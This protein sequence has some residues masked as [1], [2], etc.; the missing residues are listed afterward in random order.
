MTGFH[1]NLS[2]Y[3]LLLHH[4]L[5]LWSLYFFYIKKSPVE[6]SRIRI[7]IQKNGSSQIYKGSVDAAVSIARNY[8]FRGFYKGFLPTWGRECLGQILYFITYESIIRASVRKDQKLSEAPL[9]VSLIGGGLAGMA[10]WLFA[11]PFDYV[12]TLLQTDSLDRANAKY[13]G[14]VNCFKREFA[15]GGVP[16]FYKGMGV[17]FIRAALVNAGAFF[18]FEGASRML[19]K[20]EHSE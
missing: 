1:T 4:S 6:H 19:G 12:K 13:K 11:Y 15:A 16:A 14:M 7:Q 17:A 20:T 18:S 3:L 9:S 5:L 2:L 10:F 8:G